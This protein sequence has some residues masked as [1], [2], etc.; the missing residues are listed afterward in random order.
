MYCKRRC[1]AEVHFS[2]PYLLISMFPLEDSRWFSSCNKSCRSLRARLFR[3]QSGNIWRQLLQVVQKFLFI[4]WPRFYQ[5]FVF[6][7]CEHFRCRC[8]TCGRLVFT[9][10]WVFNFPFSPSN[11]SSFPTY[12]LL[13]HWR[14]E[15]PFSPLSVLWFHFPSRTATSSCSLISWFES[16][17]LLS[18]M[19]HGHFGFCTNPSFMLTLAKLEQ[20]DCRL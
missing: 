7:S 11:I 19:Y 5:R 8:Y 10:D 17:L 16:R 15:F 12:F 14:C 18:Q 20:N 3:I 6:I 9:T 4:S 13:S 1:F 2:Y